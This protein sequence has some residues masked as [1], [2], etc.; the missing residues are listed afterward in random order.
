MAPQ[1]KPLY[2]R[3]SYKAMLLGFI[4][5]ALTL[6][7]IVGIFPNNDAVIIRSEHSKPFNDNWLFENENRF[8]DL[9]YIADAP[10]NDIVTISKVLPDVFESSAMSMSF[11]SSLQSVTVSIDNTVI[12][13][14]CQQPD[15]YFD[16]QPAPAWH[17]IRLS[18]DMIGKTL[19]LSFSS[20]YSEYAGV[21]NGIEIGSKFATVST[22]LEER[23]LSIALCF[24]IFIFGI[25]AIAI[26][27]FMQNKLP[28]LNGLLYLGL[29]S[30]LISLWSACETKAMQ[31]FTGNVQMIMFVTFL[32]IML[33]PIAFLMF[34][35]DRFK[36]KIKAA[37]NALICIFGAYFIVTVILQV[38][39]VINFNDFFI[40]FL[41]AI[42][43]MMGFVFWSVCYAY[44]KN[45]TGI[46]L[47]PI[48]AVSL[49]LCLATVDFYRY[50]FGKLSLTSYADTTSFSRIG[51][52]LMISSLGYSLTKQLISLYS[53]SAKAEIYKS[54]AHTDS[55]S[56]L[57]NRAYMSEVYPRIFN[58]AMR[59]HQPFSV[60]IIDIDNFKP[61]N[62]NYG[63]LCGD[64]VIKSVANALS[65][66]V[67]RPLDTVI[68]YGG[69]EFL[70]ILPNV[71]TEGAIFISQKVRNEISALKLPHEYSST[72]AFVTVSQ[73]IYS[74]IPRQGDNIDIFIDIA[75][76]ALYRAKQKGKDRYE[77]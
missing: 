45:K 12:Y 73:G 18:P 15:R 28:E 35:R 9:P 53:E 75:D 13:E 38:L 72:S 29:F 34:F 41:I 16:V 51:I 43:I 64:N 39:S 63:H 3:L 65:A 71:N 21:L 27:L 5:I 26:Y 25:F 37:Y 17:V 61:Y 77:V 56:G 23:V 42:F 58:D 20:P 14:Y 69:E 50:M 47:I 74:A 62:D 40:Y 33:F 31:I 7:F 44:I 22:F 76:K 24:V 59:N 66:S 46:N 8:I 48:I 19:K 60:I 30:M 36:G 10:A 68:R 57:K 2:K 6:V 52:L 54:L 11:I 67:S 49:L 55:L 32:S 4:F 70:V 1:G